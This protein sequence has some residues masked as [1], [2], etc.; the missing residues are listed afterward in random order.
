LVIPAPR[1][2]Q[3]ASLVD[4]SATPESSRLA[5]PEPVEGLI[6]IAAKVVTHA[7]YV[8]FQMAEV[9]VPKQLFLA[10]LERVRRLRPPRRCRD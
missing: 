4:N 10:I 7:R 1:D 9:A 8:I 2:C 3:E 6:K 5:C